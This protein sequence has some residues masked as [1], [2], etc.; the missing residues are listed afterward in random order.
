MSVLPTNKI[1]RFVAYDAFA[2]QSLYAG[3]P[4]PDTYLL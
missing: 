2:L 1:V 3:A 4:K